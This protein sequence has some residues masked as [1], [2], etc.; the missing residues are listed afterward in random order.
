M[1]QPR[2][3]V[4]LVR[5]GTGALYTGIATDVA[6][7][8]TDHRQAQG[9]GAKYLRGKGPLRLV[10]KKQIGTKGLALSVEKRI[11]RLSKAR[12][13]ASI[14]QDDV[15]NEI[16]AQARRRPNVPTRSSCNGGCPSVV[17]AETLGLREARRLALAR[18]G[19]LKP[20]WT[21]FPRRAKGH[22]QRAREAAVE[23]IRRFGYLQLDTVS[24][25]GARSHTIVLL[26][27]LDGFDPALGEELLRPAAPL[28]EYWGHEASWIPLELYPALAFRR[29]EFRRHPWWGDIVGEHPDVARNL[30]RR[31]RAEGP[32]RSVDMEGRG[33]RGW[34]NLK[35][36][37]RVATALWSSGELAIRERVHFQ[38]TYDLAERV[39]PEEMR[40]KPLRTRDGLEILLLKAL[41]GH[42]WATT[43][44]LAATWRLRNRKEEITD[45]LSRL[46]AKGQ[47][48]A[49]GLEDPGRR[50]TP[51]WIRPADRELAARL[52]NVR[53]R[54]DRGVLL[55]P[56]DPLL[57]DRARVRRLF[58]FDQVLEVFKPASQRTLATTA[59]QETVLAG[60]RLIARF[61]F[62]ADRKKGILHVLSCRFEG[63]NTS[64][65][66]TARDGEAARTALARFASALE[67]KPNYRK[68]SEGAL[69][70]GAPLVRQ[71]HRSESDVA[72]I[73]NGVELSLP[74]GE[75]RG[76]KKRPRRKRSERRGKASSGTVTREIS[77]V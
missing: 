40:A 70:L 24:I 74:R 32:L 20:E 69:I 8:L 16:I 37:K 7:R 51:G 9:K 50:P 10:F 13:E 63:T 76:Q 21:G 14:E 60:E 25:A 55:S 23:V 5:C 73:I 67:L 34:W 68:P 15:I 17:A 66:T 3:S 77:R 35:T 46:A 31:I 72:R 57:W 27:R 39:I 75:N 42:G 19:L 30:L 45:A 4:Y 2:W 56:F 54:S 49:C 52:H 65:P 18:A 59:C 1:G 33:S 26:S 47:I 6:R 28:F 53:P 36:A 48:V 29:R 58:E 41:D 44:T 62:K 12:K 38:R 43:G 64:R 61:D 71:A 11:K 22:G